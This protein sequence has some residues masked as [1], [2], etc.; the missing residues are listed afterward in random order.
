MIGEENTAKLFNRAMAERTFIGTDRKIRGG[1]D[2]GVKL[3]SALDDAASD[4]IP[5]SPHSIAARL[6]GK[7]ADAYNKQKAGNEDVRGRIAQM[8]TETDAAANTE[9]IDR[10]AAILAQQARK[11]RAI[12]GA[13]GSGGQIQE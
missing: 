10:I 5:T 3:L 6:L 7:V 9:T 1:S 8:L 4:S 11:P 12:R 2:T 13:A